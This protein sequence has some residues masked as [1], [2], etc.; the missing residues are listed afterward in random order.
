MDNIDFL[1]KM[2]LNSPML[3]KHASCLLKGDSP[4]NFGVNK[5][6]K[7]KGIDTK[8]MFLSIHAEVDVMSSCKYVKGFDILVIRVNKNGDLKNSR[9][10]NNCIDKMKTKGIRKIYWS[11]DE[12]T[13]LS[14]YVDSMDKIH[15]SSGARCREKMKK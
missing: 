3:Q 1:K 9:P 5:Y 7:V 10:C 12:Q 2:A 4:T 6:F 11:T 14:E 13:I 8:P 15:E